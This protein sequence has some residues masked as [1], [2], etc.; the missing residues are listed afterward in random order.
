M[1]I[2]ISIQSALISVQANRGHLI[3]PQKWLWV[4]G[5]FICTALI[6]T[7]GGNL[8]GSVSTEQNHVRVKKT[9]GAACRTIRKSQFLSSIK[10]LLSIVSKFVT[11][12]PWEYSR[13]K[14]APSWSD[15]FKIYTR[16]FNTRAVLFRFKKLVLGTSKT[17]R[18][19]KH[20]TMIHANLQWHFLRTKDL[21]IK[22]DTF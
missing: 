19:Q 21:P 1:L 13:I 22:Y 16:Q 2:A 15:P 12:I 10:G 18:H 17:Q 7:T 20:L 14:K 5:V 6:S 11:L 9:Q 4:F 3:F 8:W